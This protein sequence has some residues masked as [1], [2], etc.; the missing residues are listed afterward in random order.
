MSTFFAD[1]TVPHEMIPS[2]G[3]ALVTTWRLQGFGSWESDPLFERR[4]AWIIEPDPRPRPAPELS[5]AIRALVAMTQLSNRQL[6]SALG[7]TH[8]TIKSLMAGQIPRRVP[9][10]A[11]R[12]LAMHKLLTRLWPLVGEDNHLMKRLL[13][14]EKEGTT[15]LALIASGDHTAAYLLVLERLRPR[16]GRG[17]IQARH[18]REPGRDV[19]PLHDDDDE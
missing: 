3:T 10:L 11:P 14:T 17:L 12:V 5:G 7:T 8:P 9:D 1:G 2:D 13:T 18:S 15:P 6:A 4:R 19:T 16:K